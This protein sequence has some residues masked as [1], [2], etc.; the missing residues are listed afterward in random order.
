MAEQNKAPE[1]E[2]AGIIDA[3]VNKLLASAL[4]E[5][6]DLHGEPGVNRIRS[7]D[8]EDNLIF[9]EA[10]QTVTISSF[11]G[12]P[13]SVI[14]FSS[15]NFLTEQDMIGIAKKLSVHP[16]VVEDNERL[17]D[18]AIV[19]AL[20]ELDNTDAEIRVIQAKSDL[21]RDETRETLAE[22]GRLVAEL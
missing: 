9:S 11:G 16:L 12:G 4:H 17:T 19:S 7:T 3:F 21:A 6:G 13:I 8:A 20:N 22:I 1:S 14:R 2:S 10:A 18:E 15:K 5:E